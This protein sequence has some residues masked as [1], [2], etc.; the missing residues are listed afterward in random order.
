MYADGRMIYSADASGPRSAE[1]V[2]DDA[3]VEAA[4]LETARGGIIRRGLGYDRADVAVIT[5]ITADHLG[6]DGIDDLDQLDPASRRSSRRKS[7][8]AGRSC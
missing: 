1:M 7:P 8:M 4:V 5:N 2:L 6:A 3:S